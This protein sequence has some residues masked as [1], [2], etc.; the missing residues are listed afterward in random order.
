MGVSQH[1]LADPQHQGSIAMNQIRKSR[2]IP[3]RYEPF[4]KL[5]VGSFFLFPP[6]NRGQLFDIV[7]FPCSHSS[8]PPLESSLLLTAGLAPP[9]CIRQKKPPFGLCEEN[10]QKVLSTKIGTT[11]LIGGPGEILPEKGRTAPRDFPSWSRDRR[12]MKVSIWQ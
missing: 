9:K 12:G 1:S 11:V 6:T 5:A 10:R 3:L 2:F 8:V 7:G 4:Q